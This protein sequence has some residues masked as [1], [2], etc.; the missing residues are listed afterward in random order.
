MG[1]FAWQAKLATYLYMYIYPL[2]LYY[3][4]CLCL[5]IIYDG[6]TE[7]LISNKKKWQDFFYTS[8]V[9]SQFTESTKKSIF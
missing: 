3:I 2:L 1:Q 4:L 5:G 8:H 6:V 7:T 9:P